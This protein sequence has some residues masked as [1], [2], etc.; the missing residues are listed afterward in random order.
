MIKEFKI[1]D[2]LYC[3]VKQMFRIINT[4]MMKYGITP[5]QGRI[6]RFLA[7]RKDQ[8]IFQKD[9]EEF[10]NIR[11]SS[12]SSI[13]KN[14]EKIGLIE[15]KSH[16]NDARLK[17]I[18]L[19]EAGLS[20]FQEIQSKNLQI[21]EKIRKNLSEKDLINLEDILNKIRDNLEN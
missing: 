18:E 9:I 2:K 5:Q 10:Q 1:S 13:L 12:V 4:D 6:I 19:T 8:E 20:I 11:K 16:L 7:L 15:R 3:L 21:E 14:L 17:K